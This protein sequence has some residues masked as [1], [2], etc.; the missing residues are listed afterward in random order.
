MH[1]GLRE[2]LAWTYT[3]ELTD[4]ETALR[5]NGHAGDHARIRGRVGPGVLYLWESKAARFDFHVHNSTL[6]RY[7]ALHCV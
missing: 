2:A 5:G 7:V 3:F 4:S 1:P 6:A